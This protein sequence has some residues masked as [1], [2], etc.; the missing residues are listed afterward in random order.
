MAQHVFQ[1]V[2][3][4]VEQEIPNLLN[5]KKKLTAVFATYNDVYG[6]SNGSVDTSCDDLNVTVVQGQPNGPSINAFMRV[7]SAIAGGDYN[8]SEAHAENEDAQSTVEERFGSVSRQINDDLLVVMYAGLTAFK[9]TVDFACKLH[10][11]H[12]TVVILTCD[13]DSRRKGHALMPF[14]KSGVLHSVIETY[15]CGGASPMGE[16]LDGLV[17]AWSTREH[18]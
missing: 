6:Y 11:P 2:E 15:Q 8:A 10:G 17:A 16:I 9:K 7:Y 5:G 3:Q 1:S 4:F 14:L 12:T 13:C 18:Q